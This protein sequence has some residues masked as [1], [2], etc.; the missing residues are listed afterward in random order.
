MSEAQPNAG[1][2]KESPPV[3]IHAVADPTV[4]VEEKKYVN[5]AEMF[6]DVKP[7]FRRLL[8]SAK[9]EL[10]S[11]LE[12]INPM[13][14]SPRVPDM[15][16]FARYVELEDIRACI[17]GQDPYPDVNHAHGLC[18][19]TRDKKLPASLRMIYECLQLQGHIPKGATLPSGLLVSW[20]AAGVLMINMAL[21]TEIGKTDA[22][23]DAWYPYMIKIV[24]AIGAL[25]QP[26]VYLLWGK[27]AQSVAHLLKNNGK[28]LVLKET[29]PSPMAQ[30]RLT[31][32]AQFRNCTHFTQANEFLMRNSR[33]SIDWNPGATHVVYTD[34]SASGNGKGAI[35][36]GGYAAYFIA[37][38]LKS[39]A[40][41]G[42]FGPV[43]STSGDEIIFPSNIR[44]EGLAIIHALEHVEKCRAPPVVEV[45]TD[46]EFWINMV[47]KFI[48]KWVSTSSPFADHKNPDLVARL[49]DV[50]CKIRLSGNVTFRHVYSHGKD[51][52]ISKVDEHFNSC[53][54]KLATAA[55]NAEHFFDSV[56]RV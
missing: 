42:R 13:T 44:G 1:E 11:A 46:S 23:K 16:S 18:F 43:H 22:H 30:A 37:G 35:A 6:A 40:L 50:V 28:A 55:R 33:G 2:S 8:L 45:V 12:Q 51:T 52:S 39:L 38:P 5:V 27:N 53:A 14:I 10:Q 49:W 19:S 32:S 4:R 26:I 47:G 7:S 9:P 3:I 15:L 54:D 25:D 31:E 24:A 17:I 20:A 34:G 48:P 56:T 21:T 41:T 36:R 29:H